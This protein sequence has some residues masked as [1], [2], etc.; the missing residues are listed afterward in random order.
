MSNPGREERLMI[1]AIQEHQRHPL[2]VCGVDTTPR[3]V[4]SDWV[5]EKVTCSECRAA[6]DEPVG[7]PL[8]PAEFKCPTCGSSFFRST[9]SGGK[10]A[11]RECKGHYPYKERGYEYTGCTF[12]WPI[13]D[14]AKYGLGRPDALQAEREGE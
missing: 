14:D 8:P 13:E 7:E 4:L 11:G 2:S 6:L 1:H 3:D 9:W 10:I 5:A 12:S